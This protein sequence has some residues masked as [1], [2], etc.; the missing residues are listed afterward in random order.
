MLIRDLKYIGRTLLK[1]PNEKR[2]RANDRTK[3]RKTKLFWNQQDISFLLYD[4][5][6]F[7]SIVVD[8]IWILQWIKA[9]NWWNFSLSYDPFCAQNFFSM[10]STS[11]VNCFRKVDIFSSNIA[12][13]T[14]KLH[15][16]IQKEMLFLLTFSTVVLLL[17]LHSC[18]HN[19]N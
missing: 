2:E 8:S 17:R 7:I 1:N 15:S 9:R 18:K 5:F 14:C 13:F 6:I 19:K 10:K 11:K 12:L 4:I 16:L 3:K